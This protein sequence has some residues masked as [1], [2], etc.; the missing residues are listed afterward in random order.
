MIIFIFGDSIAQGLW[1]SKGGWVDRVKSYVQDQEIESD[2]KNYHYV[3]NLGVDSNTTKQVLDRFPSETKAHFWPS[4]KYAFI[5]ATGT[6]DSLHRNYKEFESTTERYAKKLQQL[7]DFAKKYS[8]KL[9]FV[10]ITPVDELLTN[11]LKSS[12]TGKCY[13]NDRIQMFN[14]TLYDFCSDSSSPCVKVSEKFREKITKNYLLTEYTQTVR[15][16]N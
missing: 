5:F 14:Q 16:I 1:D 15:A 8:D 6:N 13:T 12:T 7:T 10:D 4:E 2:L 3:F 11:P 9:V